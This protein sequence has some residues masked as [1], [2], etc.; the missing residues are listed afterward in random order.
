MN[1]PDHAYS[2]STAQT[3]KITEKLASLGGIVFLRL[4]ILAAMPLTHLLLR[5]GARHS[6]VKTLP[7]KI[8]SPVF[9]SQLSALPKQ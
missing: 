1:L 9:Q 5:G 4:A 2:S 7:P 3:P 6:A 8:D